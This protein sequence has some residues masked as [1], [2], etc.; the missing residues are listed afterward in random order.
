MES[1]LLQLQRGK[2]TVFV[3][4]ITPTAK[5]AGPTKVSFKPVIKNDL[6][7]HLRGSLAPGYLSVITEIGATGSIEEDATYEDAPYDWDGLCG[8]ATPSGTGP[9][10]YAYAAPLGTKATNRIDTF[11]YGNSVDGVYKL[12][13][14]IVTKYALKGNK[15]GLSTVTKEYFGYDIT[16]GTLAAL[17]DRTVNFATGADTVIYIDTWGGTIGS[18][19]ITAT[20]FDYEL[21]IDTKRAVKRHMSIRADSYKEPSW[22]IKLKL[23]MEFNATSKTFLDAILAV[24]PNA[25]FQKQVRIKATSGANIFQ[26]D[27]AGTQDASPE[28]FTDTDGVSS[29]SI[30][31]QGMY[32]P[33]LANYLKASFTNGVATLP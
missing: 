4:A 30:E 13:G 25:A 2:Q 18:T 23:N 11:V 32:N 29:V 16:T 20:M 10:V 31:L 33:T 27:V 7:K 6:R 24:T 26:I 22:D 19:A 28:V 21:T 1:E 12:T 14:G 17:S 15:Q 8:V 3:T 5:A 9:Y